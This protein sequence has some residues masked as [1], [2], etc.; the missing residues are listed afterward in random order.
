MVSFTQMEL[1][2]LKEREDARIGTVSPK[3]WPQVTPIIYVFGDGSFYFAIDFKTIKERNLKANPKASL[4]ID[5]YARQPQAIIVQG[6]AE[7]FTSGPEFKHGYNLLTQRHDYFKA[8]PFSENEAYV[9]KITPTTKAS[10]G[11]EKPLVDPTGSQP[12]KEVK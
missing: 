5:V 7:L 4:A 3:G 11:F 9:V 1:E 10:W 6:K 12:N 8:N 2:F